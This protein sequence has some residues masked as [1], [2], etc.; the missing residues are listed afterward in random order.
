[1]TSTRPED[2]D[3]DV[4]RGI[5]LTDLEN[6]QEQMRHRGLE[7]TNLDEMSE[8]EKE[9]FRAHYERMLGYS[10]EG[11][12]FWLDQDPAV[13][14]RYRL[15]CALNLPVKGGISDL[16]GSGYTAYYATHGYVQGTRYISLWNVKN[17]A[18]MR[19]QL[20]IAFLHCGPMG[21]ETVAKAMEGI[22]LPEE[23][24]PLEYMAPYL[25]DPAAFSTGIDFSDPELS[26]DEFE[27]I[28]AWYMQYLGETPRYVNFLGKYRPAML[29][30][31]RNRIENMLKVSP[32]QALPLTL[33]HYHVLEGH[34]PGIR[35]NVL[36][37]RGFG[38]FRDDLMNHI[39]N[40]LVYAGPEGASLVDEV[41]GDV[42]D[43]WPK[44]LL[45]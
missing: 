40:A 27:R 36:W 37:S 13:L 5:D 31:Y 23:D 18:R 14:K 10:H 20:A 35:E 21:M 12:N 7:L 15:W 28:K 6:R 9:A 19:E 25:P 32:K 43:N 33:L 26:P 24:E 45:P 3:R 17:K 2:L 38:V 30:A 29:K 41:V 8:E 44:E 4:D 34:G 22:E 39:G 42:I 11:L 16:L 1:M